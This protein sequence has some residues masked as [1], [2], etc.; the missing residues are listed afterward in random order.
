MRIWRIIDDYIEMGRFIFLRL[1]RIIVV[2]YLSIQ[3]LVM[4]FAGLLRFSSCVGHLKYWRWFF[5]RIICIV[6]GGCRMMIAIF[7][8]GGLALRR[9]LQRSGWHKAVAKPMWRHIERS[10]VNA[11]F[12]SV[13]S[14]SIWFEMRTTLC[15]M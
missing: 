3:R 11:A 2:R 4:S 8:Y 7:R 14:G 5:C 9:D 12:G 13:G 10:I 15:G 1:L 6:C